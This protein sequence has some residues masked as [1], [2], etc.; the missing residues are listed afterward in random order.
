MNDDIIVRILPENLNEAAVDVP[1]NWIPTI[2]PT[3]GISQQTIFEQS[4]ALRYCIHEIDYF[5][6]PICC[7][8]KFPCLVERPGSRIC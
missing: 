1:L 2:E 4:E 6:N 3:K 8:T 7:G 5:C